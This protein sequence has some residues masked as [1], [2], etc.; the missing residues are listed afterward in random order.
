MN[1]EKRYKFLDLSGYMFSG[2]TAAV[3][4]IQEFKGYYVPYYRYE[5]PLIRL[6]DGIMDLEKALIDDWSPIRSDV[7]VKRF[8]KLVTK[9]ANGKTRLSLKE[10]EL[11]GWGYDHR[12]ADKFYEYSMEYVESLIDIRM[13]APWPYYELAQS[14]HELLTRRLIPHLRGRSGRLLKMGLSLLGWMPRWVFPKYVRAVRDLVTSVTEPLIAASSPTSG[15]SSNPY[16]WPEVEL[17]IASGDGFYEKTQNYL[18]R[19]LS[20]PVTDEDVHTI[21]MLNAFE[22][23]NPWRPIRYFKDAKCI[24]VDR[25]PRDIYVTSLTYS[26]GFNDYPDVYSKIS[27]AFNVECFIERSAVRRE[28]TNVAQDPIGKVLRL[29]FEELVTKYERVLPRIY[30]FLGES[31]KTHTKK[32][33]FFDPSISIKNVGIWKDYPHQDEIEKIYRALREYCYDA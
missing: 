1:T 19:I 29:R 26:K 10:E 7:A 28:K 17:I 21:V 20:I 3:D 33:Q 14:S 30:E 16:N 27:G 15:Q 2:K 8:I 22:P 18:E 23:Y 6:Q 11:V 24:I 32:M 12:F 13:K 25:D 9:L 5:F 4:L 31:E